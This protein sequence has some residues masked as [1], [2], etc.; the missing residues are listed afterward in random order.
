[1]LGRLHPVMAER[2]DLT[3]GVVHIVG[4]GLAGLSTAVRL[5][6]RGKRV[7]LHEANAFAGGRC[8]T[9]HDPRLEREID[10]GNHL[11]LSGN[12]S[13]RAYLTAIGAS[14]RLVEQPARFAFVDLADDRRWT[15]AMN[16]GSWK[17]S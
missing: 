9:F 8:R 16:R 11:I 6:E 10:N 12:R 14:D 2:P 7:V 15:V 1:M 17:T 13:A 4:A 3:D 5:A